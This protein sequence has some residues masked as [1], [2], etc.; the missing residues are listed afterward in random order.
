[1]LPDTPRK[2][3]FVVSILI[4]TGVL[5][6]LGWHWIYVNMDRESE[7]FRFNHAL[8]LV[9]FIIWAIQSYFVVVDYIQGTCSSAWACLPEPSFLGNWLLVF[10]ALAWVVER[11][12]KLVIR[13]RDRALQ[14]LIDEPTVRTTAKPE[15]CYDG[16]LL[17]RPAPRSGWG[18]GV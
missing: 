6:G 11:I 13:R 12:E 14:R 2:T 5:V 1:M 8:G 18:N 3:V 10:F 17:S 7:R 4:T 9:F 16:L 15:R